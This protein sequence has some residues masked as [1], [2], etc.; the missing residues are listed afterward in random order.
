MQSSSCN[1]KLM[2]N[3][4]QMLL[5]IY[6]HVRGYPSVKTE[7][8]RS[9]F[10]AGWNHVAWQIIYQP[11]G[12]VHICWLGL[13]LSHHLLPHSPGNATITVDNNT[14]VFRFIQSFRYP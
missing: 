3:L 8:N 5:K 2:D 1:K 7:T 12:N 6:I 11:D 14:A 9:T 10:F 13:P 4:Q